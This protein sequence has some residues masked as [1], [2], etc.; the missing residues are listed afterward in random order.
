[1]LKHS[2]EHLPCVGVH[3]EWVPLNNCVFVDVRVCVPQ[4]EEGEEMH[5]FY[6]DAKD[7]RRTHREW[8]T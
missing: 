6:A 4:P 8:R 1:M 5:F 2:G 3:V 7:S